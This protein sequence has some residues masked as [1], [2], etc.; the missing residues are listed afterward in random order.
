[1]DVK[2]YFDV[3]HVKK[4]ST[5]TKSKPAEVFER[6]VETVRSPKTGFSWVFVGIKCNKSIRTDSD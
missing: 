6:V 5:R 3:P 1:M 2:K 4:R